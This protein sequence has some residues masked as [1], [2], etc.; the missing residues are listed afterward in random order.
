MAVG[1]VVE[2]RKGHQR[3]FR[4]WRYITRGKN[5]GRVEIKLGSAEKG[6]KKVIVE[7]DAVKRWP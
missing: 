5:R 6:Q 3:P 2:P 1:W 4:D 7:P